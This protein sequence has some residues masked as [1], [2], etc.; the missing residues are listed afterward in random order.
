MDKIKVL[1]IDDEAEA[2]KVLC[3]LL[4]SR[5]YA[6]TSAVS[7][8]SGL[9]FFKKRTFDVVL[10]DLNMPKMSGLQFLVKAK[11]IKQD[12]PIIILSSHG[13]IP[14]AVKAIK[15]G[16]DDF[17]LEP[18]NIEE[19][20]TTIYKAI[21]KRDLK[22][23]LRES[24]KSLKMLVENVPDIIYSLSPKGEFIRLSPA[25]KD[26]LGYKPSELL[27]RPFFDIVHPD[28]KE[29]VKKGFLASVKATEE[30]IR[31]KEF[32][33]LRK[34]GEARY[35]EVRGKAI[36]EK[37]CFIRGD[38][39]AR[40]VTDRKTIEKELE[41]K[42]NRLEMLLHELSRSRDELQAIMDTYPDG[43]IMVD[44]QGRI[45]TANKGLNAYF[46]IE[47]EEMID[48]PFEIF[49]S[50]IKGCFDDFDK[51]LEVADKS[52]HYH[53]HIKDIDFDA[54]HI[55]DLSVKQIRPKQRYIHPVDIAVLDAHGVEMGRIW[56]FVDV[57]A[58]KRSYEQLEAIVHASPM[59]VL[60][61]RF[62]DGKI[63]FIN[64]N[65][66]ELM[67]YK[68][69]GVLGKETRDFYANQEDRT[70][71]RSKLEKHGRVHNQEIQI[72]KADGTPVW[73]LLSVEITQLGDD[74]V[75]ISGLYDIQERKQAEEALERERN[76]ISTILDTVS[77]LVIVLDREGRI[78]RFNKTCEKVTGYS[79]AELKGKPFWE[80][81]LVP[82]EL[83]DV[84]AVFRE[85]TAGQ[86]PNKHENCWLT[87]DGRRR[88]ISW[89]NT[90]L[91]NDKDEVEHIIGT[92]VDLTEHR[93]M[94]EALRESEQKYRELVENANSIIMRWNRHGDITF[95]N[96]FAQKFFGYA[97]EDILG[98]NV[99]DSIVP[100]T[101]QSGQ[102]L[103][104]MIEDIERN[105]ENYLSNEN[106]NIKRTGERVWITWTNRPVYDEDG[107]L[108][109]IL[110]IGKDDTDRKKAEQA[111]LASEERFRRIVENAYDIIHAVTP[112]LRMS[113]V[114]PNITEVL[115]YQ[116]TEIEGQSMAD[117]IHP[118]DVS[119]VLQS[120]RKIIKTG[121]KQ[122]G[123]EFR[124]RHKD[125]SWR[126]LRSNVSPLKNVDGNIT[127]LIGI[128]HDFTEWKK[129]MEDLEQTNRN[130]KRAQSQ[131]VQSEK[132]ASLGQL[133]AG[134]AHEINTPIGAV[135]SMHDTLFRNLEKMRGLI[136]SE[137]PPNCKQIPRLE[138]LFKLIDDSNH[139]IRSGTD[140]VINIVTRLKSFARLDEAE[141]K[142]VDIHEG[143]ED[144]LVLIHHEL[145]HDITI[146]KNY[147][148]VPP[149]SCYPSQL[150]QV[151][152]NLL[153]NS[154]QAIKAK[155]T[156]SIKTFVKN[157]K[158]HI[159]FADDGEGIPEKS[160]NRIFDPGYTTKGI[161][162]G[163]GLGL[164]ITYNIIQSH[165]GTIKVKSKEGKGT[166][167]TI[168][169]PMNLEDILEQEKNQH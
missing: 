112:D 113:Y 5:N 98:K 85:L 127:S 32:R 28:D 140:R 67:G 121:T 95:F 134:I 58:M 153:V 148:Q 146:K 19:I 168:T 74:Q 72:V 77:A 76:F 9:A 14:A 138:S 33:M 93:E 51:F 159:I 45:R 166:T 68:A 154:K 142:T 144:T 13:T 161:G 165:R 133:V 83:E 82:E 15:K 66:A 109:E 114:S 136:E 50:A 104:A 43:M 30:E 167:F 118:D 150:N 52:H 111:L 12:I 107:H 106:E 151:F 7:G 149:I 105:P 155:G 126:W 8:Q 84:K 103:R 92:G 59:P 163:T 80:K 73:I 164:S 36:I 129:V 123:I 115:G 61:S 64:D 10:C 49:L 81:L 99:M 53:K 26:N 71:I 137:L 124:V 38:G 39:I 35:F 24:E 125:K 152:L 86:F 40:D 65:L 21:E 88:L 122:S 47:F 31:Q 17:I 94:E 23:R 4:H 90:A 78:V 18:P 100:E 110:S 119:S 157:K 139:V 96:E 34:S 27:G 56:I 131:L 41:D 147:G 108:K 63:F 141:L 48:R 54:S 11:R 132:M 135:S 29:R 46:G 44:N 57:T 117:F 2:R 116:A 130:L 101:D 89:V 25:V 6:V 120:H 156:I 69:K 79:F 143:I 162:V 169:L 37:G 60:V 97:E 3:N 87:R 55:H 128:A 62:S 16:A 145:K 70:N 42:N 75:A 160:L 158:I 20:E 22:K 91:L 1:C 102:D